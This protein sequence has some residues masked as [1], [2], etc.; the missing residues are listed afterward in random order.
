[1][2]G[3]VPFAMVTPVTASDKKLS[4]KELL[5]AINDLVRAGECIDGKLMPAL[6][7]A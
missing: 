2:K 4:E 1:M 3:H 5:K 7:L 6:T